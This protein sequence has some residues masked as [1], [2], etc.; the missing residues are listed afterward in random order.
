MKNFDSFDTSRKKCKRLDF[1]GGK[2]LA[3]G[4]GVVGI[5]NCAGVKSVDSREGRGIGLNSSWFFSFS[6]RDT[7]YLTP[8]YKSIVSAKK[9]GK[10]SRPEGKKSYSPSF[11]SRAIKDFFAFRFFTS[12][13]VVR[14]FLNLIKNQSSNEF[15]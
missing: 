2:N 12:Q 13:F 3:R 14:I 7:F 6:S 8:Q 10:A 4:C 1:R 15:Y 9:G 5:E 11:H